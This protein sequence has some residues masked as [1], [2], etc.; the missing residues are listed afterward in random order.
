MHK[1][2]KRQMNLR[3]LSKRDK[4]SVE[5]FIQEMRE[6]VKKDPEIISKFEEYGVP[7]SDI[8][9]V[10][11][12]FCKLEVSAKTKNKKI[13]LNEAMLSGDSKVKDPTHYLVHELIHYLQQ[14]TGKNLSKHKAEDSY[15]DKQTEQ[16]AF[17]SQIDYMEREESPQEAE[18]Y[19]EDLLDHH[20]IHGP[21]RKEKKEELLEGE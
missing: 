14:S 4:A 8:D 20:D 5:Q 1:L 9:K 6:T 7:L 19:V 12:T 21:D 3:K 16:E 2:S 15:L 11:V 18:R 10:Q 13:Y 17:R